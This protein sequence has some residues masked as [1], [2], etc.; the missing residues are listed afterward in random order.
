M[1]YSGIV[2]GR[3]TLAMKNDPGVNAVNTIY[4]RLNQIAGLSLQENSDD[5]LLLSIK[6]VGFAKRCLFLPTINEYRF[7][8]DREAVFI[9]VREI[10]G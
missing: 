1:G 2:P 7:W 3:K 8:A 5:E 10:R 6:C 9:E 4:G